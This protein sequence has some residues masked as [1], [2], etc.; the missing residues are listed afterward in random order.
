L[1]TFRNFVSLDTRSRE[2]R[3][4][5]KEEKYKTKEIVNLVIRK[6]ESSVGIELFISFEDNL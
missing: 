4:K 3:N 6:Y 1:Q 2:I 5:T